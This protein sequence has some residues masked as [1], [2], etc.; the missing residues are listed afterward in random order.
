MS[1]PLRVLQVEDSE[2]DAALILRELIK[3]GYAVSALRVES[4]EDM[5]LAIETSDWDLVIADYQMPQFH[6]PEALQLLQAS[7]RDYPFIVVSGTI[8]ESVAVSMMRQGAHDYI[9][10]DSL[11][12]LAPAVE[13]E[14]REAESRRA[15]RRAEDEQRKSEQRLRLALCA[16]HTGVWEWDLR[17]DDV[18]WSLECHHV[19]GVADFDGRLETFLQMVHPNDRQNMMSKIDEAVHSQKLFSAEFRMC[20]GADPIWVSSLGQCSYDDA[21]SP[22]RLV[23]TMV[24][25]TERKRSE[26][27]LLESR[28]LLE[29][30][31]AS[32]LDGVVVVDG[33]GI[34]KMWNDAAHHLFGYSALEAVGQPLHNMVL[35]EHYRVRFQRGFAEYRA[36]GVGT[37]LGRTTELEARRRDGSTF[38]IELSVA[39]VRGLPSRWLV[40]VIRD[41]TSRR[42][43]ETALR[44]SEQRWQ[45]ALEGAGDGVFDWDW[46]SDR[47]YYSKQFNRLLGYEEHELSD[48]PEEW[49]G[50]L[51]PDDRDRVLSEFRVH[52]AG[53]EPNCMSEFRLRAKDGSYRW[54]LGRCRIVERDPTGVPLRI[55]GILSDISPR[56]EAEFAH[57]RL[58]EQFLQS[59]KMESLGRMAGGIA[60]DFNNLLTVING[61]SGVLLQ[62]LAPGDPAQEPVDEIHQAGERAA[63]L[64]RQLLAFSRK[65]VPKRE[66]FDITDVIS[67]LT[68]TILGL[69]GADIEIRTRFLAPHAHILA[70]RSQFEQVL[71]NLAVNA[72]DAMPGGGVLTIETDI[73][74]AGGASPGLVR[75]TVRDTGIGMDEHTKRHLF[76]PFFTTKETG[77]GTGLGLSVVDGIVASSGGRV[78]F[79]STLGS[80]TEFRIFL[81]EAPPGQEP[82]PRKAQPAAEGNEQI[83][84]V[85]DQADVRRFIAQALTGYGYRVLEAGDTPEALVMLRHHPVDLLLTDIAMPHANGLELAAKVRRSRP[86]LPVLYISGHPEDTVKSRAQ[87]GEQFLSKPFAPAILAARIRALLDAG[88]A[89]QPAPTRILVVDDDA[90]I[91]RYV[92]GVLETAGYAVSEAADGRDG[93][94]KV[95]A[96]RPELVIIDLV[97][98]DQEG[99]ETIQ[100]IRSEFPDIRI[101]AMSGAAGGR[102]LAMAGPLGACL[103]L[104]KPISSA[105]LLQNVSRALGRDPAGRLAGVTPSPQPNSSEA[106]H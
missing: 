6:A 89:A 72:R 5:R 96:D 17:T 60:H 75:I 44:E 27:A 1:Q 9:M 105:A 11:A 28:M 95:R 100:R 21:G 35:P 32:P 2:G 68:R 24:D 63:A 29:S 36:T 93:L 103:A 92:H 70:D 83:L 57:D 67:T 18:F 40:G 73:I 15:R 98:P 99:L 94:A 30:V 86:N 106:A 45:F 78:E 59:H 34:V 54:V 64:V 65:D 41:I 46:G 87:F 80:G 37:L 52:V 49:T 101:I 50:R 74:A 26:Q 91:R 39:P 19:L 4:P 33:E 82:A 48:R 56:K 42:A 79:D 90:A 23:C 16:S 85:E 76:D 102:Y 81:P 38:P 62:S 84:L 58:Q 22:L 77:R 14:L 104:Q 12:R 25:V 51:H 20:T 31:L 7:G 43:A 3:A 53:A 61:W 66:V 55:I 71:I 10:K 88:A 8:G 47:I 13:R 97:M 69:V